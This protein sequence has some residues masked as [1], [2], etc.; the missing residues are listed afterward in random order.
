MIKAVALLA[1]AFALFSA[2]AQAGFGFITVS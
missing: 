1:V 2:P